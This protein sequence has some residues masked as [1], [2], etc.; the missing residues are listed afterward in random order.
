MPP[1]DWR[2]SRLRLALFFL[3]VGFVWIPKPGVSLPV[4]LISDAILIPF[5]LWLAWPGFRHLVQASK[6]PFTQG[7]SGT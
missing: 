3:V 5:G 1:R 4:N 2:S 6:D 7:K